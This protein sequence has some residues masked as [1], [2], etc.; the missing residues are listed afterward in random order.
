MALQGLKLLFFFINY[1]S[2]FLAG[3]AVSVVEI[4]VIWLRPLVSYTE[5]HLNFVHNTNDNSL[6]FLCS[7]VQM[8]KEIRGSDFK[9]GL[10][11]CGRSLKRGLKRG[12]PTGGRAIMSLFTGLY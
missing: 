6:I 9:K 4:V 5:L 7:L 8:E 3:L 10:L 1:I 12:N 2:C 11:T